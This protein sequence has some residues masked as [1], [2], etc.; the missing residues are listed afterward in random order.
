MNKS[1]LALCLGSALFSHYTLSQVNTP[2]TLQ[3]EA[4]SHMNGVQLENTSDTG[5][6]QNVGWIDANDWMAYSNS[7]VN[8]TTSGAY[9]IEYR[10]ASPSGGGNIT[11]EEA[12]GTPSFGSITLPST[13]GWQTW[14][15]IKQRVTL[16][17]GVHRFGIKVNA[18]GF[19][20]NWF[21]I[22]P[23]QDAAPCNQTKRPPLGERQ[24]QSTRGLARHQSRQLADPRVLD[25][26]RADVHQQRRH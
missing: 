25:D 4:Y 19:N 17:A 23:V 14:A 20:L 22:V 9:D 5:G 6:G 3:A 16:S 12:G 1:A 2:A 15:T 7:P 21:R 13:G 26:G 10:Y 24:Y 11:F 8:I 18:G